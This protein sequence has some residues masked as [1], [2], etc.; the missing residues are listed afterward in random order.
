[1]LVVLFICG[2]ILLTP[3]YRF[4]SFESIGF[5]DDAISDIL[6]ATSVAPT[7]IMLDI[8]VVISGAS[9]RE[10]QNRGGVEI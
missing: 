3:L 2:L 1:M 5:G 10:R 4:A 9:I 8:V 6:A 7:G